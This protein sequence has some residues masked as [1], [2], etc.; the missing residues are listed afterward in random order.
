M[1]CK[2]CMTKLDESC[3]MI[4]ITDSGAI[5]HIKCPN[6]ECRF[7]YQ[8]QISAAATMYRENTIDSREE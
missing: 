3:V 5:F 7:Y 6:P 1:K 2:K 4:K 8:E